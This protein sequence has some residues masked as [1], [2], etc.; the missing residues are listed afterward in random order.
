VLYDVMLSRLMQQSP[1]KCCVVWCV[2]FG[3]M[4]QSPLKCCVVWCSAPDDTAESSEVLCDVMLSRRVLR[5]MQQMHVT[6]IPGHAQLLHEVASQ[7]PHLAAAFLH[8]L[9][10]NMEPKPSPT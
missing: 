3:K 8:N 7:R 4:Q 9:S 10:W 2:C 5:L 1:L 6:S